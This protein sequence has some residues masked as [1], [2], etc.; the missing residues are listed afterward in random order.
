M[1]LV[2]LLLFPL[3]NNLRVI[4]INSRLKCFNDF[5]ENIIQLDKDVIETQWKEIGQRIIIIESSFMS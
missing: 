3:W 2:M 1:T 4:G 5:I